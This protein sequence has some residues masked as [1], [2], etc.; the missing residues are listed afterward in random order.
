MG[1]GWRRVLHEW[2][3]RDKDDRAD[4]SRRQS[5][6]TPT[7]WPAADLTAWENLNALV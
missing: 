4:P 1:M 7:N 6:I 5:I 2:A 3:T